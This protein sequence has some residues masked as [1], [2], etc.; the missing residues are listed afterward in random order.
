M[1]KYEEIVK[2]Y[3]SMF[4]EDIEAII[5]TKEKYNEMLGIREYENFV[6]KERIDK[7]IEYIDHLK[8]NAPDEIALD[9]ILKILEGENNE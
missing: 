7:A 2:E 8:A 1:N 6:L 9:K 3:K 4:P 5:L